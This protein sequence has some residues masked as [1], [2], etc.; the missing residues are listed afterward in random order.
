MT[1]IKRAGR[2]CT[3]YYVVK[4]RRNIIHPGIVVVDHRPRSF[5]IWHGAHA[6]SVR[7]ARRLQVQRWTGRRPP[8]GDGGRVWW[9]VAE[10]NRIER[11]TYDLL[12]L[13]FSSYALLLLTG[14]ARAFFLY[15]C[16]TCNFVY[17]FA[18]KNSD[19]GTS[20]TP[21]RHSFRDRSTDK[22]VLSSTKVESGYVFISRRWF[23]D[24]ILIR[25]NRVLLTVYR[26]V[27]PRAPE[28]GKKY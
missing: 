26:R 13:F 21:S 2:P 24:T 1:T 11:N 19:T 6:A 27:P 10:G 4:R 23:A 3:R 25:C 20:A 18:S 8:L 12:C 9:W 16:K 17:F 5:C 14:M 28:S 15:T 7:D 22:T